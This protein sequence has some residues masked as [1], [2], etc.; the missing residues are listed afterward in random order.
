MCQIFHT[1]KKMGSPAFFCLW[2]PLVASMPIYHLLSYTI[3]SV[4]KLK[5]YG[6]EVHIVFVRV[7]RYTLGHIRYRWK[8]NAPRNT[9]PALLRKLRRA[10]AMETSPKGH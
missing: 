7:Q 9:F 2:R 5:D 6:L 8:G 1:K 4:E 3:T 10:V